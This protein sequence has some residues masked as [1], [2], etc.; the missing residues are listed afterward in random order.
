MEMLYSCDIIWQIAAG[1]AAGRRAR[2][3]AAAA[4]IWIAVPQKAEW[5]RQQ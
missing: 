4:A 1:E 5:P 2:L 3:A